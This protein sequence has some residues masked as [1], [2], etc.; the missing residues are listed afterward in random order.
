MSIQQLVKCNNVYE[1]F[2]LT[3][4]RTDVICEK[5]YL[6][7]SLVLIKAFDF[8]LNFISI[9]VACLEPFTLIISQLMSMHTF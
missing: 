9:S 4:V 7:G 8:A 2:L 5:L 3:Y 6:A 1:F